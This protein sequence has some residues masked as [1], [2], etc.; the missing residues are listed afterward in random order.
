[1]RLL[2]K[3]PCKSHKLLLP[4]LNLRQ[5]TREQKKEAGYLRRDGC[6]APAQGSVWQS[7]GM[8]YYFH[9]GRVLSLN[10]M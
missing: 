10:G 4:L 2:G 9:P 7:V 5:E 8:R 6:A 3:F 1:M